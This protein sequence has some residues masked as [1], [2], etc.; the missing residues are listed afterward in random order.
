MLAWTLGDLVYAFHPRVSM[1]AKT[2]SLAITSFFTAQFVVNH[3]VEGTHGHS[4]N[5]D[6][7]AY[8]TRSSHDYAVDSWL[9]CNLSGGLNN[10][11]AHH[12]FPGIHFKHYPLVT[13]VIREVCAEEGVEFQHSA[14]I[15]SALKKHHEH[16]YSM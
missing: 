14:T 7:G 1:D 8:Q 13:K 5:M 12:L 16:L 6:W 3:E 4:T 11:I 15:F 10:Q 9:W 2:K